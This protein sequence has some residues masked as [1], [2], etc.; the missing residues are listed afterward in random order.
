[1]QRQARKIS[2]SEICYRRKKLPL[3]CARWEWEKNTFE[4]AAATLAMW[5]VAF[6]VD[7]TV[8]TVTMLSIW[9]MQN[10]FRGAIKYSSAASARNTASSKL[11]LRLIEQVLMYLL[12]AVAWVKYQFYDYV[13]SN[14]MSILKICG[15]MCLILMGPGGVKGLLSKASNVMLA[16]FRSLEKAWICCWQRI[17]KFARSQQSAC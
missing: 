10:F 17:N 7:Q 8:S 16:T 6:K 2:L 1:M 11:S 15:S 12:I 5:H 4:Q 13:K 3:Y 9:V 14:S